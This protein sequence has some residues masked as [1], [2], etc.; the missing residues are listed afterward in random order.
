MGEQY[1]GYSF[2]NNILP[3]LE[4][5]SYIFL[6]VIKN[7]HFFLPKIRSYFFEYSF[8]ELATKLCQINLISHGNSIFHTKVCCINQCTSVC[9]N[10]IMN[11][12][13]ISRSLKEY[14]NSCFHAMTADE[15]CILELYSSFYNYHTFLKLR[16]L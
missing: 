7:K 3:H 11:S 16:I 6:T 15:D 5:L 1:I 14:L 2:H 12:L 8:W 13:K 4:Q 9:R 10:S